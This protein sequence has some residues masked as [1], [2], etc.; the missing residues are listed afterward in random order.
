VR[1]AAIAALALAVGSLL[2]LRPAGVDAQPQVTFTFPEEGAVLAEPPPMLRMCFASPVN[3]QDLH[4]GGDFRFRVLNPED[5]GLGL[6]I[7]FRPDG[8]GVDIYPGLPEEPQDGEWTL[9]WRVTEP[10]TLEP[11]EGTLRF[12]VEPGGAPVPEELPETCGETA[13]PVPD[14]TATPE[15][16]EDEDE[17]DGGAD[18]LLIILIAAACAA[19]AALLGFILYLVR[20]RIRSRGRQPPP[21]E[22]EE[23]SEEH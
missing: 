18:V 14:V 12:T 15:A 1:L 13:T 7:V 10:D 3:I 9:E 21:R 23:N 22:G 17:G 20:R 11:A 16:D 19:G 4:D 6:R 5:L 2:I 8:L